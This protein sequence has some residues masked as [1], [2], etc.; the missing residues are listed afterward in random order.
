[1]Y[2]QST[3]PDPAGCIYIFL[4]TYLFTPP[5]VYVTI[6]GEEEAINL[7]IEDYGMK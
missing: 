7:R 1:M 5:C 6:P 3:K 4:Y 2:S